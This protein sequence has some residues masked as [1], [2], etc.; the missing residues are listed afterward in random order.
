MARR[1][2]NI[3]KVKIYAAFREMVQSGQSRV[4]VSALVDATGINRKTFYNHFAN[5]DELVAWGFR[6]DLLDI[7]LRDFALED[8]LDPPDDSYA[9]EGLP[10]YSRTPAGALSLDQGCYFRCLRD[11]FGTYKD[12]YR[13]VLR[14][15][16]GEPLRRYLV[17]LFRCLLAEDV[18]YFLGGRKMP[19]GEKAF[20]ATFYA[21]GTVNYLIDSFLGIVP[22]RPMDAPNPVGNITHEGMLGI[23]EAYQEAKSNLYFQKRR[24]A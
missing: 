6:R 3:A 14:S 15:D 19:E 7:L 20:I 18:N 1:D 9:F 16:L 12:Y 8:L 2:K 10:C 17:T 13:A 11:L 4:T 22:R 24:G 21:E 5:Q 23:V